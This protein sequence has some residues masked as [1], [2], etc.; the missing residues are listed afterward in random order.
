MGFLRSEPSGRLRAVWR[1]LLHG[2]AVFL[3]GIVPVIPIAEGLTW[4]HR[5]DLFLAR[6]SKEPYDMAINMIVG[7]LMT[8]GI[9]VAT[10][11]CSRFLDHRRRADF[12]DLDRRWWADWLFGVVLGGA[13]MGAIFGLEVAFGWARVAAE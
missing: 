4:L 1:L 12:I 2:A 6:L 13:L 5:R 3:L 7:P 11:A 9:V 8:V 10:L